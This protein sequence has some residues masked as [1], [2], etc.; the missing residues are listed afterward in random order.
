MPDRRDFLMTLGMAGAMPAVLGAA[1]AVPAPLQRALV[2]SGGGAL[3]AYAAGIV[4]CLATAA[5]IKDGTAL[6]PY[7]L[8]CGTSIG[9]LNGW[10]VAT[11][12]HTKLHDLWYGVSAEHILQLKPQF[13]ALREPES[14]AGDRLA[15]KMRMASLTKDQT[16]FFDSKPILD[17]ASRHLDPERPLVMPFV[18]VTT[19]LT[20]QRPEYFY[21][22]PPNAPSELR[23]EIVRSLQVVL[24]PQTVVRE[25]SADLFH[26]QIFASFAVPLLW[27]PVQMP[28]PDGALNQYCDGGIAANSPVSIAHAVSAGADVV[29]L[30]PPLEEIPYYENAI[31]VSAGTFATM[32][33]KILSSDM[34]GVYF[35]SE[36]KRSL[37]RLSSSQLAIVTQGSPEL[38]AYI[39]S[40]PA[41]ELTY[42]RPKKKL[43]VGGAAFDDEQGIGE[44][45]R[46]G[47]NDA[48]AGFTPYDWKTFES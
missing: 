8:V 42:I 24:G 27:D 20:M 43:P 2:L 16:A 45:Y 17:W 14:G 11:G 3:G 35:Q 5:G 4:G 38:A 33:Q 13:A 19:N 39:R 10:F 25:A 48:I 44:A 9:A 30:N 6:P 23:D 29:L 18:W 36:A 21:M 7:E 15:A 1:S 40:V 47:W 46:I 32:Q 28:G 37:L 26:K 22:R 41:T 34:R 12:Q 31:E